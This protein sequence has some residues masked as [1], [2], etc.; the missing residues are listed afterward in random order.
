MKLNSESTKPQTHKIVTIYKLYYYIH[1]LLACS[2]KPW[3]V[4]KIDD[5]RYGVGNIQN[6][7]ETSCHTRKLSKT[8]KTIKR[9][10]DP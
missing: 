9:T 5:S 2:F 7:P 3:L 1:A 10:P 4:G 8:T 6:E